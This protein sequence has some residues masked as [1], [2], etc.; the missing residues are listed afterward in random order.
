M[1]LVIITEG[2]P[3]HDTIDIVKKAREKN[4]M[5]IGPNGPG[6]VKVDRTK[7]GTNN[8]EKFAEFFSK[9]FFTELYTFIPSTTSPPFPGVTPPTIIS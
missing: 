5:I 6:F 2:I 1:N 8:I 7:L 3:V 9:H 4:L